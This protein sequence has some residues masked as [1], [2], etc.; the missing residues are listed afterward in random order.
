KLQEAVIDLEDLSTGV[1]LADLTLT[2]FRIDLTHY[3][4]EHSGVLESLPIG[5]CAV[6][7][8]SEAD[9]PTGV[10]FCLRAEEEAAKRAAESGYPLIPHY[11]VH[12]GDDGTVLLTYTQAKQILDR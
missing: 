7:T 9:V 3:L 12:V 1:S 4:K 8:A 2:D 6:T 5:I 11:L 10:I